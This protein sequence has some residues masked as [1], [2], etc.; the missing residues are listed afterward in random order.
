M[1]WAYSRF[2][3]RASNKLTTEE[4]GKIIFNPSEIF[5]LLEQSKEFELK[6][7]GPF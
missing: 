4:N 6:F 5:H 3:C 7:R 1:K 2:I